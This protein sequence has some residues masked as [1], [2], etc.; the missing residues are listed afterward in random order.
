M[1]G[2]VLNSTLVIL[3]NFYTLAERKS[4]ENR[5]KSYT[6]TVTCNRAKSTVQPMTRVLLDTE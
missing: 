3:L 2:K 5:H 4:F 6:P 1:A